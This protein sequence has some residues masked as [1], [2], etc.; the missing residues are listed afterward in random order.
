MHINELRALLDRLETQGLTECRCLEDFEGTTAKLSVVAMHIDSEGQPVDATRLACVQREPM[1][2]KE[3]L[4]VYQ[5][6]EYTAESHPTFND[7][8]KFMESHRLREVHLVDT[9]KPVILIG[10]GEKAVK[11]NL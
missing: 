4:E 11:R 3:L 10:P 7:F 2:A 1:D 9:A 8:Y 5:N 6:D